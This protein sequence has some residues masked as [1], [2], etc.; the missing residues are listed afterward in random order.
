MWKGN[1]TF[2]FSNS[3]ERHAD[4]TYLKGDGHIQFED[5]CEAV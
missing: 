4:M 1:M 5:I 2:N 3:S